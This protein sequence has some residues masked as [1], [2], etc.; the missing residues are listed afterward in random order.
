MASPAR[1]RART[2]DEYL[3]QVAPAQRAVLE[4]LRRAIGAAAPDAEEGISYGLA[5]FRLHG[6][7]LAGFGAS[8]GHCAYYPMSGDIVAALAREL[9]GYSTSKGTIRFQPSRPLPVSL[10][11]K[12]VNARRA[13]IEAARGTTRRK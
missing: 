10:I 9:A 12:L 1:I 2:V 3:A 4:R 8:A 13:E 7:P 11:R 6:R 5:A